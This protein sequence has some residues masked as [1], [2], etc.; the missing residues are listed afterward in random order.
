MFG[1]LKRLYNW[2]LHWAETPYAVPA[3]IILA[4]AESSFFP[5]PVDV[6]LIALAVSKPKKSFHYG[7]Y[8]SLFSVLGGIGGYIIGLK[9][10]E[11]IGWPI[12]QLYGYETQFQSLSKTFQQYNF[13]A[14]FTA[15]LTPIPYKVFT[16]TAGAVRANFMEFMVASIVGRSLRFLSVAT[17]IYFFGESVKR[18][19]EKYFNLLSIIF[20]CLLIGGFILIKYIF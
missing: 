1:F 7:I 12:I 6:L 9:F 13:L 2:V 8:T 10:M 19:I 15:A 17:L 11:L 20:V 18:F 14:V 3:L 4:I 5:V 16:I